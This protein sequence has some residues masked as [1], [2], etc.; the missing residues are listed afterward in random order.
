[1]DSLPASIR[2]WAQRLL[3]MEAAKSASDANG[4]EILRVLEKLRSSLTQLVGPD[5][6]VSL[7][8][9]ALALARSEFP[10]LKVASVT[11]EGRL[12]GI[13]DPAGD[14]KSNLE[15]ATAI[16]AHLLGLL[17]T[18]IGEPITLRLMSD[19]WPDESAPTTVESEDF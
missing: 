7:M 15:A 4:H 3:A 8:R 18:F 17:V 2:A 14:A 6:F 12:E 13:E 5:G 10:S 1:M 11:G 16:I 9:R 19:V